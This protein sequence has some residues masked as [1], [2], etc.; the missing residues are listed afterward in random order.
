M[1]V[2]TYIQNLL[3]GKSIETNANRTSLLEEFANNSTNAE[4]VKGIF[5]NQE[6]LW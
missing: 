1:E 6:K 5:E 4:L 2:K 3:K